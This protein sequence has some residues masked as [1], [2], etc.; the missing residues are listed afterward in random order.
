MLLRSRGSHAS[1]APPSRSLNLCIIAVSH[2]LSLSLSV[3]LYETEFAA[4][5]FIDIFIET[6]SKSGEI[7]LREFPLSR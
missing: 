2:S 1:N 6:C 3:C 7:F 5:V 4:P